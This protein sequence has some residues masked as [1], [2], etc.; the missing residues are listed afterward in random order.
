MLVLLGA[1]SAMLIVHSPSPVIGLLVLSVVL[2]VEIPATWRS[3]L[4]N[5]TTQRRDEASD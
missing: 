4:L 5:P 1:V 3:H 2:G